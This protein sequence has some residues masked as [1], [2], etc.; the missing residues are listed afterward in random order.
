E[1]V[2]LWNRLF[3]NGSAAD[4]PDAALAIMRDL[5]SLGEDF[6]AAQYA[7]YA[8]LT[9]RPPEFPNSAIALLEND[10][11]QKDDAEQLE[12]LRAW[13]FTQCPF[14]QHLAELIDA[15]A[16]NSRDEEVLSAGW[17]LPRERRPTGPMLAAALHLNRWQSFDK[18]I[19]ELPQP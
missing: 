13:L 12:P 2:E 16:L 14:P 5:D 9:S 19:E 3:W 8:L 7:H 17:L 18:L 15:F 11:R 6:L 10:A 4:R 1:A